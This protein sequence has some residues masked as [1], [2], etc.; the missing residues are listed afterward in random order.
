MAIKLKGKYDSVVGVS[1]RVDPATIMRYECTCELRTVGVR[2]YQLN[3]LGIKKK[4]QVL[5]QSCSP[6]LYGDVLLIDDIS[7]TEETFHFLIISRE[8]EH[9]QNYNL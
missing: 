1:R 9:K 3:G 8:T 2:S 4:Y 7:D 5:Y 6:Y